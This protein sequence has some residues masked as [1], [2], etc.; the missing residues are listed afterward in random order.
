MSKPSRTI[1]N[2]KRIKNSALGMVVTLIP[3]FAIAVAQYTLAPKIVATLYRIDPRMETWIVPAY[4]ASLVKGYPAVVLIIVLYWLLAMAFGKGPFLKIRSANVLLAFSWF[5]FAIAMI[6]ASTVAVPG[7][8]F[9]GACALFELD[10]TT[11]V[12]GLDDVKS[13]CDAFTDTA[14]VVILLGL[15]LVLLVLSAALRIAISRS[16]RV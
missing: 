16:H 4:R 3:V 12:F 7:T 6:I 9:R 14:A 13:E 11:P 1:A 10:K 5:S 8:L 15:P 2:A